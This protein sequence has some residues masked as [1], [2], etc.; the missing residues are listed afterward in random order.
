MRLLIAL[1]VVLAGFVILAG[2]AYAHPGH[3]RAPASDEAAQ[4]PDDGDAHHGVGHDP[5]DHSH[6]LGEDPFHEK[7][8][9]SSLDVA[10]ELRPSELKFVTFAR[11]A[12]PP[13]A[14][15]PGG[16][17]LVPPVPPPLG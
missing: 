8:S 15:R 2:A 10:H 13:F 5:S 17:D 11:D 6:P 3:D 16:I 1:V 4:A 12:S 7:S 9:H 14:E